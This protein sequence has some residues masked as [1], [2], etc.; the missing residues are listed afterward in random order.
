MSPTSQN[1][2]NTLVKK[3]RARI[4]ARGVTSP[5]TME[6]K[7]VVSLPYSGPIDIW[8]LPEPLAD[9]FFQTTTQFDCKRQYHT[10]LTLCSAAFGVFHY[11]VEARAIL[12]G[13][14]IFRL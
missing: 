5:M 14:V 4:A 11:G 8:T 1:V 3:T 13:V 7:I 9:T 2:A 6:Y 12:V 10:L